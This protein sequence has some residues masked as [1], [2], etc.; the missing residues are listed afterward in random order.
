MDIPIHVKLQRNNKENEIK[1]AFPNNGELYQVKYEESLTYIQKQIYYRKIN[2]FCY[3]SNFCI[4]Y[5]CC[6]GKYQ[7][8]YMYQFLV[9]YIILC[10]LILGSKIF[11]IGSIDQYN[12]IRNELLSKI[13]LFNTGYE[14]CFY[15]KIIIN[16]ENKT[17]SD[18]Y[19]YV[20]NYSLAQFICDFKNYEKNI[21]FTSFI[22]FLLK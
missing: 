10:F 8:K 20:I 13:N 1:I 22:L 5:Y 4:F 17:C 19:A 21:L 12:I 3:C 15:D 14:T 2:G 6:C 16:N 18:D 7:I 11:Q 9:L